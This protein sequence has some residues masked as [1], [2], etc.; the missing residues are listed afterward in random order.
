MG[1]NERC[2]EKL[3]NSSDFSQFVVDGSHNNDRQSSYEPEQD[4]NVPIKSGRIESKQCV[5]D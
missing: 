4:E 2:E 5:E 1:E 3:I